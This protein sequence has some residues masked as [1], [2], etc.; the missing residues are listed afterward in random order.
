[1]TTPVICHISSAKPDTIEKIYPPDPD[2]PG[3]HSGCT[4][5]GAVH[6]GHTYLADIVFRSAEWKVFEDNTLIAR[7]KERVGEVMVPV[8]SVRTPYLRTFLE[9]LL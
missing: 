1:M 6:D 5:F 9:W 4:T 8:S 2:H 7:G 3:R